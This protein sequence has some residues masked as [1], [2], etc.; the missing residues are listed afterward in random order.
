M[1]EYGVADAGL[2]RGFGWHTL[3]LHRLGAP[4]AAQCARRPTLHRDPVAVDRVL[5]VL[6]QRGLDRLSLGAHGLETILHVP[7]SV[8]ISELAPHKRLLVHGVFERHSQTRVRVLYKDYIDM[9]RL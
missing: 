5:Y 8:Q 3:A 4:T 7:R 2:A 9:V 1:D 6:G